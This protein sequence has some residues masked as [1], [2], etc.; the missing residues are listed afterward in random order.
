MCR[1][2]AHGEVNVRVPLFGDLLGQPD[3]ADVAVR[4]DLV[5]QVK[6]AVRVRTDPG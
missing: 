2:G 5:A 3:E 4:L 6:P 1:Y